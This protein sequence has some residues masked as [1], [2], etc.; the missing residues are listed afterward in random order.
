MNHYQRSISEAT[1]RTKLREI[2]L[3][4][5]C[6]RHEIFHSTLDWQTKRQFNSGARKAARVLASLGEISPQ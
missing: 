5:D 6:M 1:G 2:E 4:E 3:I